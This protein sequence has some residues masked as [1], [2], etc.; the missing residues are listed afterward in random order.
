MK[1]NDP[2]MTPDYAARKLIVA[3]FCYYVIDDPIMT[4]ATYDR[5]SQYV[6]D[7]W[8]ELS[9]DRRWALRSAKDVRS[10]GYHI[11][12][13]L[14]AAGAALNYH[15]YRTGEFLIID[16]R[17]IKTSRD[18]VKYVTTSCHVYKG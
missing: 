3:A 2:H 11:W 18:G 13:S 8:D 4:D 15:K 17:S 1:L 9:E 16:D 7:H 12:F 5:Y 10:T 6:A 14:M